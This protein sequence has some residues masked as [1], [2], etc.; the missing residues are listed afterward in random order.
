M[1]AMRSNTSERGSKPRAAPAS[2]A[3]TPKPL[4]PVQT[5]SL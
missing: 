1:R 5:V 3:I 4:P 2:I